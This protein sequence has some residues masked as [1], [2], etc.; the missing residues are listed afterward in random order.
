MADQQIES[1]TMERKEDVLAPEG[2][3]GKKRLFLISGI[4]LFFFAGMASIVLFSPGV[5]P[6]SLRFWGPKDPAVKEKPKPKNEQ[7]HIYSMDPF[8]VNLADTESARYLKVK[9]E[10]EGQEAK[11]HEEYEKRLPQLR[12]AVLTI[13]SGKTY[14]EL[15]DSEGK[16]KLKEEIVS[17]ANQVFTVLKVKTVY[18]NEFVVQ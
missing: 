7:G 1:T 2:R 15:F 13:L 3:K 16:K 10:I 6:G 12:D 14:K 8:I 17:K 18:F 4:V 9:I 11:V 5:I